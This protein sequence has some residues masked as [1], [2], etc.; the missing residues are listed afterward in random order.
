VPLLF[1]A[2]CSLDIS[3]RPFARC[4]ALAG[5]DCALP[6]AAPVQ[7]ADIAWVCTQT[8]ADSLRL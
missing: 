7:E 3:Q 8:E 2:T 6:A 1:L 4:L 5:P